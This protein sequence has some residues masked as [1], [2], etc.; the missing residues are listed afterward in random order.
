MPFGLK[1]SPKT[2]TRLVDMLF[3]PESDESVF[4][5]MDDLII[6]SEVNGIS[7]L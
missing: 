7:D 4:V 3:G 2:F 1:G 6:I 5:Y